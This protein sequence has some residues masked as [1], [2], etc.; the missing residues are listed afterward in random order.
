MTHIMH[1]CAFRDGKQCWCW[2]FKFPC[3]ENTFYFL[4]ANNGG[5]VKHLP[6][7]NSKIV[8]YKISGIRD[9]IMCTT[10]QLVPSQKISRYPSTKR[11]V[12]VNSVGRGENL[13]CRCLIV[14]SYFFQNIIFMFPTIYFIIVPVFLQ[15]YTPR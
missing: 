12:V 5:F 13:N 7:N 11:N 2:G 10:H 15:A 1:M 4:S 14:F 6:K 9:Y 8:P 3:I